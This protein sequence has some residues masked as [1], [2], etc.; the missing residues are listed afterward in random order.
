[1]YISRVKLDCTKR[2]TMIALSAVQ[3]IHGAVEACFTGEKQR[4]LWRL[5]NLNGDLYV[6]I[7]SK[8]SPNLLEF[9]NQFGFLGDNKCIET[10]SYDRFLGKIENGSKWRFRLTANPTWSSFKKKGERGEVVAHST[11]DYQKKWL[12]DHAENNGFSVNEDE[13]DVVSKRWLSFR[14]KGDKCA[15]V[16]ILSVTFEGNLLI[17]DNT[18]FVE[19]MKNGIGRGKAYGNGLITVIP[20]CNASHD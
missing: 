20:V 6:L 16:S 18:R 1:M 9:N 8:T 13:F 11:I 19:V 5:D 4:K 17:T 14:H 10:K 2:K 12:I 3:K 15:K 7:V